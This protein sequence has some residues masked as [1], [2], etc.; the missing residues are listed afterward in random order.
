[1]I[2]KEIKEKSISKASNHFTPVSQVI[3]TPPM[4]EME[5]SGFV[6]VNIMSADALAP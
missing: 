6:G 2:E 1:M 3:L 4:M 5:Y